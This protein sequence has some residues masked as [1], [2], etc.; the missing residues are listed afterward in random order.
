[1]PS[2]RFPWPELGYFIATDAGGTM[3]ARARIGDGDAVR[4]KLIA[5]SLARLCVRRPTTRG[6][7]D[8]SPILYVAAR[9]VVN[10]WR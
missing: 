5:C 10:L 3:W 4:M 7:G 6:R 2:W 9:V 8:V 1:M